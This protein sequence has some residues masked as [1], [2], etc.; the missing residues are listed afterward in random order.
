MATEGNN[1]LKFHKLRDGQ[2]VS[3]YC[4]KFAW[5][6]KEGFEPTAG[7]FQYLLKLQDLGAKPTRKIP[8][9]V[10]N[11]HRKFWKLDLVGPTTFSK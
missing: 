5:P 9:A 8:L 3:E 10:K 2:Y 11:E 6:T 4:G 7:S 1:Q